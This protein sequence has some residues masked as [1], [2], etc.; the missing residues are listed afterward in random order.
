MAPAASRAWRDL[1]PPPPDASR[2]PLASSVPQG[3]PVPGYLV[4]NE[5]AA[6]LASKKFMAPYVGPAVESSAVHPML[7]PF[8]RDLVAWAVRHGRAALFADTGLGKTFMQLEWARLIGAEH[9]LILAPLAVAHQT[10]REGARL[11]IEVRYAKHQGEVQPGITISNYERLERFDAGAFGAVVLDESSILKSFSGVTKRALIA[12]FAGTPYRLACSATPAP[13]DIEELCNH[14]HF[15]GVMSPAEMRSTFFIADSRGE[16]MRYRLKRHAKVPFYR[17]LAS[18]SMAIKKPSDLGYDDDGFILPPLAIHPVITDT[19]WRPDG[20]LFF[21]HLHGVVER[22]QVRRVTVEGR[23]SATAALIQSEPDESWL[24]WCGLNDEGRQ[25]HKLL[26]GSV[27]VE[28][29]DDPEEKAAA[30]QAFA[31]GQTKILISKVS[32]AGF[33]MNFQG[34]ARMAFLGLGDSFEMYYQAI[35][36]CWRFGQKRPVDAYVVVSSVERG[37]YENVLRKERQ[38]VE[39]STQLIE[40][41]AVYERAELF[42]GTSAADDFLPVRPLEVPRWLTGS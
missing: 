20:Q 18:W 22:S 25:L 34:C 35:R 17:W 5:Y 11:G 41:A 21:T 29:A 30:L 42:A 37:V 6:F 38:A 39:L 13:N 19:D 7:F 23:V 24:I 40:H 32:I 12:E 16:F 9:T 28:G 4:V 1:P 10:I 3:D 15:L 27:L 2:H 14:A 31:A 8:Q 26:P 33:G 36:R